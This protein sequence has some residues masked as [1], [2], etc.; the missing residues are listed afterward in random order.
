MDIVKE[1]IADFLT[2]N[3]IPCEWNDICNNICKKLKRTKLIKPKTNLNAFAAGIVY[4]FSKQNGYSDPQDGRL[5]CEKVILVF[6]L[7]FCTL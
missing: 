2:Q 5:T 1:I 6:D 3:N 4:L 7:I